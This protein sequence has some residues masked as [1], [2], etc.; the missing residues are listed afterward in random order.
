MPTEVMC[1]LPCKHSKSLI[2]KCQQIELNK[3]K[4]GC[5]KLTPREGS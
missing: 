4:P 1:L 5:H 3:N 2:C